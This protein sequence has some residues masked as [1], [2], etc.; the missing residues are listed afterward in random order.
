M[1]DYNE[2]RALPWDVAPQ[3][4]GIIDHAIYPY[5]AQIDADSFAKT[6]PTR[7][8]SYQDFVFFLDLA[9]RL[10]ALHREDNG[11]YTAIANSQDRANVRFYD[12]TD[13]IESIRVR[14]QA[15]L[16]ETARQELQGL[17]RQGAASQVARL[18]SR[19]NARLYRSAEGAQ[20]ILSAP[21]FLGPD[22]WVR[23]LGRRVEGGVWS[24]F[25]RGHFHDRVLVAPANG[26][27]LRGAVNSAYSVNWGIEDVLAEVR[28]AQR[29]I[30]SESRSGGRL[31]AF[32]AGPDQRTPGRFGITQYQRNPNPELRN[33]WTVAI[34][35]L[36]QFWVDSDEL[37]PVPEREVASFTTP[38]GANTVPGA[39]DRGS[40]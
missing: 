26:D 16:G 17:R 10:G 37:E 32:V 6:L 22:P 3:S 31:D 14:T 13:T 25:R 8:A 33:S 38:P 12:V 9:E 4:G 28:N 29:S 23:P 30:L 40:Q 24:W 27:A 35:E 15:Q 34:G 21:L 39:G 7:I 19:N 36:K 2:R 11:R 5:V 20:P 1:W 18:R